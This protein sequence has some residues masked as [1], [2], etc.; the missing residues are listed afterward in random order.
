MG[1]ALVTVLLFNNTIPPKHRTIYSLKINC[2]WKTLKWR[3][4]VSQLHLKALC[5]CR[6]FFHNHYHVL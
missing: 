3:S 6:G 2:N 5:C 1:L 4:V